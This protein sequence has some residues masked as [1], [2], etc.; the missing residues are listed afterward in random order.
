MGQGFKQKGVPSWKSLCLLKVVPIPTFHSTIHVP[1][2]SLSGCTAAPPNIS[3]PGR[4]PQDRRELN[5]ESVQPS[6]A[7]RVFC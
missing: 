1:I 6:L 2:L 5:P 4:L 7:L 3:P